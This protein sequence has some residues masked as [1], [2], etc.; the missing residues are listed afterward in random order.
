MPRVTIH[1]REA[2]EGANTAGEIVKGV[3]VTYS[4]PQF[5]P[6]TLFLEG[7]DVKDPQ[8]QEAIRKDLAAVAAEKPRTMDI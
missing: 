5:P 8:V 7:E 1:R 6:R 4:T 3:S 2:V